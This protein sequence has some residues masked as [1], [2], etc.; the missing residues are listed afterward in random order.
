MKPSKAFWTG[1]LAWTVASWGAVS[2][3]GKTLYVDDDA[4]DFGG[5]NSDF[6]VDWSGFETMSP[7]WLESFGQ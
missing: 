5:I 6:R 4:P 2:T 3:S 7:H 1:L